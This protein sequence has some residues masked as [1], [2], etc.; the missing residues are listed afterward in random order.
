[1][2]AQ[3]AVA[4]ACDANVLHCIATTTSTTTIYK[5]LVDEGAAHGLGQ[6]VDQLVDAG[7]VSARREVEC[8]VLLKFLTH[9]LS[10]H[11]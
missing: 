6:V 9:A 3:L 1:M 10:Q 2:E 5:G 8:Q 4:G 11:R 7:A